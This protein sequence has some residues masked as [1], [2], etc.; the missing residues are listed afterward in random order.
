MDTLLEI[1]RE[2]KINLPKLC[3]RENLQALLDELVNYGKNETS[4]L[5]VSICN[6]QVYLVVPQWCS[7]I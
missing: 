7:F 6:F 1:G 4:S 5:C 2:S 3:K